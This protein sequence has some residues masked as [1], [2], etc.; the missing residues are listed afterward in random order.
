MGSFFS[1]CSMRSLPSGLIFDQYS[2][3]KSISHTLFFWMSISTLLPQPLKSMRPVSRMYPTEPIENTSAW[4]SYPSPSRSSG[5]TNPG[6]P[7]FKVSFYPSSLGSQE[8]SPKSAILTSWSSFSAARI[9]FSGFR[10]L[11]TIFF[12]LRYFS[13]SRRF[14]ITLTASSSL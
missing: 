7:H 3:G 4:Q 1:I 9:R 13:A 11:C 10:S 14:F 8:A 2:L 5:A 6:D 12:S